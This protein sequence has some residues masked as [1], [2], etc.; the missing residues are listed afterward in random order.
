MRGLIGVLLILL[1]G[2]VFW[3]GMRRDA[4]VLPSQLALGQKPAPDFT[5]PTLRPYRAQWGNYLT[6]S[7]LV[8]KQPI[9]L[10][11][12]ASWCPPCRR[13]AP[14]LSRYGERY[15][16]RVLFLGLNFRDGEEAALAFIREF[17]LTFPSGTDPEGRIGIDYGVYGLP[18]TFFI[19]KAGKVLARQVGEVNE[20]QLQ[21]Y[22][23]QLL[24]V[25]GQ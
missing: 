4:T 9:V 25:K 7:K 22:L 21:D 19:S 15:K 8:G 18:E 11:F 6:L 10:N 1:I 20:K 16:G 3:W 24:A 14:L 12:W 5:A 13:E 17:D 23:E 2:G